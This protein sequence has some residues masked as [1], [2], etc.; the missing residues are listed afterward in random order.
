MDYQTYK[1]QELEKDY[2]LIFT[3]NTAYPPNVDSVVYLANEIM[4]LVWKDKPAIR[5][6]IV[7]AKPSPKVQKLKSILNFN[8]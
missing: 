4:P 8:N 2:D 7:G 6:V 1:K 3:G 5:L